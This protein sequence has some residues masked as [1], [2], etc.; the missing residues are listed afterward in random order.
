MRN[1]SPLYIYLHLFIKV[2]I[3]TSRLANITVPAL[4]HERDEARR[5]ATEIGAWVSRK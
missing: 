5:K 3:A 2:V 1:E 4:V